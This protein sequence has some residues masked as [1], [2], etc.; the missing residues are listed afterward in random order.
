MGCDRETHLEKS[1]Q[2]PACR[3][4][5]NIDAETNSFH[6]LGSPRLKH[7][8]SANAVGSCHRSRAALYAF[9][10]TAGF[11]PA[12]CRLASAWSPSGAR[13]LRGT[14]RRGL[15]SDIHAEEPRALVRNPGAEAEREVQS[16]SFRVRCE[17]SSRAPSA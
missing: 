15:C 3:S 10:A 4:S 11:L 16:A 7:L 6:S 9:T 1:R 14:P 2:H 8:D 12:P 17:S 5:S 13:L